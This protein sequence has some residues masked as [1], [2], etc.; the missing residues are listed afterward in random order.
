NNKEDRKEIFKILLEKNNDFFIKQLLRTPTCNSLIHQEIISILNEKNLI[1]PKDCLI[2]SIQDE[3][4]LTKVILKALIEDPFTAITLLKKFKIKD[5]HLLNKIYKNAIR[6]SPHVIM[7][8]FDSLPLDKI[9]D[10]LLIENLRAACFFF[11]LNRLNEEKAKQQILMYV[12]E[13]LS[14]KFVSS[15]EISSKRPMDLLSFEE[16]PLK[17]NLFFKSWKKEDKELIFKKISSYKN[18]K[19]A[20]FLMGSFILESSLFPLYKDTYLSLAGVGKLKVHKILPSIIPAKWLT[21]SN[22]PIP[23]E[24]LRFLQKFRKELRDGLNPLLQQHLMASIKLDTLQGLSPERKLQLLSKA[25][26]CENLADILQ[27]LRLLHYFCATKN[28]KLLES[29]SIEKLFTELKEGLKQSLLLDENLITFDDILEK[30]TK[31]FASMRIPFA[32]ETYKATVSQEKDIL[33]TLDRFTKSI[34]L[35]TFAEERYRTDNNPHL[36]MI[37]EYNPGLLNTWKNL[38]FEEDCLPNSPS[39]KTV[40]LCTGWEDLFLSGTEV[41]HSCLSIDGNPGSNKCLLAY[42]LD[43]KNAMIA[44]KDLKSKLTA[45][46]IFRLLWDLEKQ[47]PALFLDTIYPFSYSK[48]QKDMILL[49]AKKC[50]LKLGLELYSK[51]EENTNSKILISL[52]SSCPFE[53]SNG[54]VNQITNGQYQVMASLIV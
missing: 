48:E 29:L 49:A 54:S 28:Q 15:D 2:F 22:S 50:S 9:D 5:K 32:L 25:S 19:I 34:L 7:H 26:N 21:E 39:N 43:G 3:K 18:H 10:N 4:I 31:T 51:S 45:R 38:S 44:I 33:T 27:N 53:Y 42:P 37:E 36:K 20:T 6:L 17:E 14:S 23:A 46:S 24:F 8:H 40:Q 16:E 30:Y 52:G 13:I 12:P 11:L 1:T 47:K 35:G 41:T